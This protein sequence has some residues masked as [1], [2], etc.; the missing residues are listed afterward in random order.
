MR[1]CSPFPL[2]PYQTEN[3][4]YVGIDKKEISFFLEL[5]E[6]N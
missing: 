2:L 1:V 6:C 3:K 5:F 4:I